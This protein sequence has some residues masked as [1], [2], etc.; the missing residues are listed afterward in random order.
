MSNYFAGA[1]TMAI[2]G[3]MA[4]VINAYIPNSL[5]YYVSLLLP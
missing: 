2:F 5:G 1:S 4:F 3:V